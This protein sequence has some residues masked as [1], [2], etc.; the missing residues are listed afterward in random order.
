M[1]AAPAGNVEIT[2]YYDFIKS[3]LVCSYCM[4]G[5]NALINKETNVFSYKLTVQHKQL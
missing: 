2:L 3:L 5:E 4:I 1:R